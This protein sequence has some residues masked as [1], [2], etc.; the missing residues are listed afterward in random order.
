MAKDLTSLNTVKYLGI[1]LDEHSH[2]SKELAHTQ[3]KLN[4]RIVI[5]SKLRQNTN[6]KTL[7]IVYHSLFGS[8]T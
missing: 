4:R 5:L 2:W 7:K 3:V 8:P 6:L 1:H